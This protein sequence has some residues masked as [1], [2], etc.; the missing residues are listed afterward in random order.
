MSSRVSTMS[1]R[2]FSPRSIGPRSKYPA[3]SLLS[4]V[5]CPFSSWSKRKNSHSGPTSNL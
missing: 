2:V 5:G 4:V 3:R 1:R